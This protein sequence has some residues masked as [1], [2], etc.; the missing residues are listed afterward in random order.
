MR[1]LEAAAGLIVAGLCLWAG[2]PEARAHCDTMEGP[3]VKDAQTALASRDLAPVLKWVK[4]EAETTLREAFRLTL[5]VRALGPE[6]RDLADRSFLETLVRI[7]REGEGEPYTG[8]KPAGTKVD[9]ALATADQALETGSVEAL[10]GMLAAKVEGGLRA[11][12]ARA[13][14]A[15]THAGDSAELGRD[16]VAAYVEFLH[17]AERVHAAA[18][19]AHPGHGASSEADDHR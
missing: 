11:R 3:V 1:H 2:T 5:A 18:E 16:Y 12:F 10:A 9:P 19:S 15:R 8:I 4:P 6:A 14:Q 17:Y 13:A 7:H